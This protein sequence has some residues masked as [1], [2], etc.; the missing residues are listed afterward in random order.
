MKLVR[1]LLWILGVVGLIC[2]GLLIFAPEEV[3]V[4]R[5]AQ[6]ETPAQYAFSQVNNLEN[7][8]NWMPWKELDPDMKISYGD[9]RE[10]AGAFY[11]WDGEK[12]GKGSLTILESNENSS[13]ETKLSF[14]GQGDSEGHWTFKPNGDNTEVSWGMTT[15]A[16][17]NPIGRFVNLMMDGWLGKDFEKG[18]ANLNRE[19]IALF[20]KAKE[21]EK[22]EAEKLK[23]AELEEDA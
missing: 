6:V 7:W 4:T 2:V 16:G 14:E 11:S 17:M 15:H 1:V 22:M 5:T 21:A 9:K 19:A 13:I 8:P 10:G 18:L 23:E 20:E 12:A 3:T